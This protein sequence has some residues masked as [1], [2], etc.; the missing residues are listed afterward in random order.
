MPR[1]GDGVRHVRGPDGLRA[2]HGLAGVGLPGVHRAAPPRVYHQRDGSIPAPALG[3]GG[4]HRILPGHVGC[5]PAP[6]LGAALLWGHARGPGPRAA[7]GLQPHRLLQRPPGPMA[8][9]GLSPG[10]HSRPARHHP[11]KGRPPPRPSRRGRPG[12]AGGAYRARAGGSS[13]GEVGGRRA[14]R[15]R[16]CRRSP[17]YKAQLATLF[18]SA[19][20]AGALGSWIGSCIMRSKRHCPSHRARSTHGAL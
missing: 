17:Q 16:R 9:R 10:H 19:E 12:P 1:P 13:R 4:A 11:A 3:S 8:R 7:Q 15:A 20:G 6:G 18:L 14:R 5:A 2:G